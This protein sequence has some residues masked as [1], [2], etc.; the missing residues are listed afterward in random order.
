MILFAAHRSSA[1]WL[2]S[3]CS[4]PMVPVR[5]L[6]RRLKLR[7]RRGCCLRR[8]CVLLARWGLGGWVQWCRPLALS[9]SMRS[10]RALSRMSSR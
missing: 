2:L 7:R 8:G 9:E 1:L 4:R 6:A 10:R 3:L 5:T